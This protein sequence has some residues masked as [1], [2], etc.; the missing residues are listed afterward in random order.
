MMAKNKREKFTIY[1]DSKDEKE[2]KYIEAIYL[3]SPLPSHNELRFWFVIMSQNYKS[4]GLAFISRLQDYAISKSK[5][6]IYDPAISFVYSFETWNVIKE[7]ETYLEEDIN[8]KMYL[9]ILPDVMLSMFS[10]LKILTSSTLTP[11]QIV[12]ESKISANIPL[13]TILPKII[14]KARITTYSNS[15]ADLRDLYPYDPLNFH[16]G[17]TKSGIIKSPHILKH[18]CRYGT[19][20]VLGVLNIEFYILHYKFITKVL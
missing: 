11:S 8:Y 13:Y 14:D 6:K 3:A 17:E 16:D 15:M 1:K 9:I 4:E 7:I 19:G 18:C 12:L 2:A 20:D 5:F 10:P